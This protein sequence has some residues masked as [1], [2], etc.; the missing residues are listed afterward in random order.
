[1]ALRKYSDQQQLQGTAPV[2]SDVARR[3]EPRPSDAGA[4]GTENKAPVAI[5]SP[6]D[7][8]NKQVSAE[9]PKADKS[10][11][12]NDSAKKPVKVAKKNR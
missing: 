10:A 11:K 12:K 3:E 8:M 5:V 2:E 9:K 6:L 7:E 1:M 4:S